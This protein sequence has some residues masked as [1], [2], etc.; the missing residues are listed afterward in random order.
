MSSLENSK[1]PPLS[2]SV[3]FKEKKESKRAVDHSIYSTRNNL[4][5]SIKKIKSF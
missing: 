5:I 3:F 4:Y 1:K 2:F